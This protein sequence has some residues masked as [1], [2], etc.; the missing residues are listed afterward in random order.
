MTGNIKTP[1]ASPTPPKE[2]LLKQGLINNNKIIRAN[3][4]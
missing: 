2:G 1:P 4:A 3:V